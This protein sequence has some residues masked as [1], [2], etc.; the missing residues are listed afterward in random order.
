[1]SERI[2]Q[3]IEIVLRFLITKNSNIDVFKT[4]STLQINLNNSSTSTTKKSA[5]ELMYGTKIKDV[6]ACLTKHDEI[7]NNSKNMNVFANTRLEFAK[8]IEETTFFANVKVKIYYDIKHKSFLLN[9]KNYV[10]I[11]LHHE[12]KLPDEINK[13]LKNQR[14][15]SF[16]MIKR[17]ERLIYEMKLSIR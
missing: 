7:S 4:L 6:I 1:M 16:E 13:K 15:E 12:Y 8:K 3:T 14:C 10:Y 17:V 11:R 5:T 9:S 2:N